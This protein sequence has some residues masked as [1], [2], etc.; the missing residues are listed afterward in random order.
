MRASLVGWWLAAVVACVSM[1]A[2]DAATCQVN[3]TPTV[4]DPTGLS[5]SQKQSILDRHNF[6]RQLVTNAAAMPLL[7]WSNLLGASAA[8]FLDACPSTLAATPTSDR[9]NLDGFA[10]VGQ[11]VAQLSV[12]SALDS[13]VD[14]WASSRGSFT[15]GPCAS[16]TDSVCGT[17]TAP[18]G[19]SSCFA[20]MQ[21][22]WANTLKIGCA[23]ESCNSTTTVRLSC[24]YGPGGVL[25][26]EQAYTTGTP[27]ASCQYQNPAAASDPGDEAA[28]KKPVM[29]GGG[30]L[31][32]IVFGG[33]WYCQDDCSCCDN[34]PDDG[35][36]KKKRKAKDGNVQMETDDALRTAYVAMSEDDA[37]AKAKGSKKVK[38]DPTSLY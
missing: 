33:L 31:G 18:G 13:A 14:T 5:T 25:Q 8:T 28:W 7:E 12:N 16:T 30:V 19:D 24:L 10:Y 4:T 36:K 20:Y 21:L 2:G 37:S 22:I 26:G 32:V 15:L 11:N 3:I 27:P 38:H 34:T 6:Y 35:K 17:C 23:V 9:R 29:I 1:H